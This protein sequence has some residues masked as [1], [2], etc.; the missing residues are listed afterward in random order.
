MDRIVK[1]SG[2]DWIKL[3]PVVVTST[4]AAYLVFKAFAPKK[5]DIINHSIEK[6]KD[7]VAS[8]VDIEDLGEKGVFCRCWRS[9]KFPFCDGS[10]NTHN[11]ETGDNVGPLIVNCKKA[12]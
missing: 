6:D 5:K 7:K 3:V 9:K 8:V 11:K 1:M 12:Q 10:H 2:D 4:V